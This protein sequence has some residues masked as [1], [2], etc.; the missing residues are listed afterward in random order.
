MVK[1]NK[2]AAFNGEKVIVPKWTIAVGIAVCLSVASLFIASIALNINKKTNGLYNESCER[3]N[4]EDKL[5]L[6][7]IKKV[8]LCPENHFYLDKCYKKS[9]YDEICY[10]DNH[11]KK[12]ENLICGIK[13][14]CDCSLENYW[15]I[16]LKK[17]RVRKTFMEVCN[18]E[19]CKKNLNLVCELGICNCENKFM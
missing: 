11:C 3:R 2:L 16:D 14:K 9:T 18:S 8:C 1:F 12:E 5:G 19:E 15:N 4:C 13:S 6:K 17:C 10:L 7:C